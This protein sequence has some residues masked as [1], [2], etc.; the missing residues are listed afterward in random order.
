MTT[1]EEYERAAATG[2]ID[3]MHDF[4]QHL[5]RST[6]PDIAGAQDWYG[7][8]AAGGH[9]CAMNDLGRLAERADP[10]D[11]ATA[12]EWYER[13]ATAGD[14]AAMYNLA[15]LLADR[16]TPPD[17]A[18][19]RPWYERAAAA[20]YTDAYFA[21][22]YLLAERLNPPD[23]AAAVRWYQKAAEHGDSAAMYNVGQLYRFTLQP[24]DQVTARRWYERAAAEG[25]T[26]ALFTLGLMSEADNDI[27][28]AILWYEKAAAKGHAGAMNNLG[29]LIEAKV[30]TP[31]PPAA[32]EWYE[33]AALADNPNAKTNLARL[34]GGSDTAPSAPP[35]LERTVLPDTVL[36]AN[37]AVHL[38]S[39]APTSG[40][41][42]ALDALV[43]DTPYRHNPFRLAGLRTDADSRQVRKRVTELEAAEKL[44]AP[45]TRPAALPVTPPP[46]AADVKA[47]LNRLRE[48][49]NRLV[50]E[51]FWLWPCTDGDPALTALSQ[52]EA[53]T[54]ERI[55]LDRISRD[56]IA[57]HNIA[58]LRHIQGLETPRGRSA[59]TWLDALTAWDSALADDSVWN[60]LRERASHIDDRRLDASAVADLRGALPAMLLRIQA[61][62]I[63]RAAVDDDFATADLHI[64]V[65]DRF[66]DQVR[67][68]PGAFDTPTI[69]EARGWAIRKLAAR[70]K[71]IADEAHRAG[72]QRPAEASQ[73]A[74]RMLDRARVPLR[75]IDRLRPPTD[76]LGAGAHDDI[77]GTAIF[78]DIQHYNESRDVAAS[79]AML[80]RLGPIATTAAIRDR[81]TSEW[82]ATSVLQVDKFCA[83]ARAG[84]E[85]NRKNGLQAARDLLDRTR[86]PLARIRAGN[87]PGGERIARAQDHIA[88]T[89][90]SCAVAYCNDTGDLESTRQV[91]EHIRPLPVGAEASTFVGEQITV[92]ADMLRERNEAHRLRNTC[93]FCQAQPATQ[94]QHYPFGLHR[95]VTYSGNTKR[96]RTLT[97]EVPRCAACRQAHLPEETKRTNLNRVGAVG[98]LAA[99]I[100][101]FI[102]LGTHPVFIVTAICLVVAI[103]TS[104]ALHS[105]GHQIR[106][107]AL[108][109]PPLSELR[110]EGWKLGE[111]PT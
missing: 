7:R 1:R 4:G 51:V 103:G 42:T 69:D 107:R 18:G 29:T 91:L 2:D 9:R 56:A 62:L 8:A 27:P 35:G 90:T 72:S 55:W 21:L 12:R 97:V 78:C 23:P 64:D 68:R 44:G 101:F 75:V 28:D 94:G 98:Y 59:E 82:A 41:A 86:L 11:P 85:G 79:V 99:F 50:Q 6:P 46:D 22:A 52:G 10:P 89:A 61:A 47:A 5:E 15:G 73:A 48:P 70:L 34:R 102:G 60:R 53:D 67:T 26:N 14:A 93:W 104:L 65:L 58:V 57:V 71:S 17:P 74:A 95:D 108:I 81:L 30:H 54:A 13:G 25:Y 92:L 37:G 38:K 83:E 36:R 100:T 43:E 66:A 84:A 96:W 32:T 105:M 39:V 49:V 63:V 88:T 77:V 19:A 20:E 24:P 40:I 110:T 111:R 76:P 3:A 16:T 31:N 45:L 33:R 80:E 109:Y 87:D 106:D